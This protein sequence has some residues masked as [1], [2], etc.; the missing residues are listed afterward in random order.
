K[1]FKSR[2]VTMAVK[3]VKNGKLTKGTFMPV[4]A[5]A[6]KPRQSSTTALLTAMNQGLIS[7]SSIA[8]VMVSKE[9][10]LQR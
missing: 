2:D 6:V 7:G 4:A 10:A 3:K 1:A 5:A 9:G 8:K